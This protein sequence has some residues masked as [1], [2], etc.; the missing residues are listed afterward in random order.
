MNKM[1]VNLAIFYNIYLITLAADRRKIAAT[2]L[3]SFFTRISEFY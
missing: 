2:S 1:S 3:D